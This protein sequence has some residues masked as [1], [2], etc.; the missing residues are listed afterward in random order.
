ML[1]N[2]PINA[3]Y[4]FKRAYIEINNVKN[5]GQKISDKQ[6]VTVS[7]L[8]I[9]FIWKGIL[10][11][12]I[13]NVGCL[14]IFTIRKKIFLFLFNDS[15][16]RLYI[17]FYSPN[18][19][20]FPLSSIKSRYQCYESSQTAV[21][22]AIKQFVDKERTINAC[23]DSEER[24]NVVVEMGEMHQYLNAQG[25]KYSMIKI[26]GERSRGEIIEETMLISF[27]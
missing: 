13:I 22:A 18:I 15:V 5:I 2:C 3:L 25:L 6:T 26:D 4:R 11:A 12:E 16:R 7:F 19:G 27:V 24:I 10:L 1:F 8:L 21:T 23:Y 9:F 17:F 20:G 14:L